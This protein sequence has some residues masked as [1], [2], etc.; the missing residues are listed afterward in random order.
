MKGDFDARGSHNKRHISRLHA[1]TLTPVSKKPQCSFEGCNQVSVVGGVRRTHGEQCN[2][3]GCNNNIFRHGHKESRKKCPVKDCNNL[4]VGGMCQR[5]APAKRA[6]HDLV[7]WRDVMVV[8]RQR[9]DCVIL[10]QRIR[11][12]RQG[13]ARRR[14]M[15][16]RVQRRRRRRN[17]LL[18]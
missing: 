15:L 6:P 18:I 1:P 11:M 7:L 8:H 14:R 9:V 2:F 16:L 3:E 10:M 5:H 17:D 12:R 4:Y 13:V